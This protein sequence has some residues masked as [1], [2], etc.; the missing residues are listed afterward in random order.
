MASEENQL[1]FVERSESFL[2]T[3]L[4]PRVT[5]VSKTSSQTNFS[6]ALTVVDTD[7]VSTAFS[8]EMINTDSSKELANCDS[9]QELADASSQEPT[10]PASSLE[11]NRS[12]SIDSQRSEVN[13]EIDGIRETC[14]SPTQKVMSTRVRTVYS[15][16]SSGGNSGMEV[17]QAISAASNPSDSDS[18]FSEQ[19]IEGTFEESGQRERKTSDSYYIKQ[20]YQ[21]SS[22]ESTSLSVTAIKNVTFKSSRDVEI[23][24]SGNESSTRTVEKTGDF[25]AEGAQHLDSPKDKHAHLDWFGSGQEVDQ[26]LN[27]LKTAREDVQQLIQST[28]MVSDIT[29]VIDND[30]M[31][32]DSLKAKAQESM[33]NNLSTYGSSVDTISVNANFNQNSIVHYPDS[34]SLKKDESATENTECPPRLTYSPGIAIRS[35]ALEELVDKKSRTTPERSDTVDLEAAVRSTR[36][37]EESSQVDLDI[38]KSV[39]ELPSGEAIPHLKKVDFSQ[40]RKTK[41]QSAR[42]ITTEEVNM[43]K[44]TKIQ[45]VSLGDEAHTAEIKSP[46]VHENKEEED[47]LLDQLVDLESIQ[48]GYRFHDVGMM[49]GA[50]GICN[51][52]FDDTDDS[53]YVAAQQNPSALTQPSESFDS[54]ETSS[55]QSTESFSLLNQPSGKELPGSTESLTSFLCEESSSLNQNSSVFSST[56]LQDGERFNQLVESRTSTEFISNVSDSHSPSTLELGKVENKIVMENNDSQVVVKESENTYKSEDISNSTVAKTET[57]TAMKTKVESVVTVSKKETGNKKKSKTKKGGNIAA[58]KKETE[59][60]SKTSEVTDATINSPNI[61]PASHSYIE[62]LAQEVSAEVKK[63]VK[64]EAGNKK[65]KGKNRS[66][67]AKKDKAAKNQSNASAED[68]SASL[69][70]PQASVNIPDIKE[71][72]LSKINDGCSINIPSQTERSETEMATTTQSNVSVNQANLSDSV[73]LGSSVKTLSQTERSETEVAPTS[74]SNINVNQAN[75]SDSVSLGSRV[76]TLSQTE[77]SETEVAPTSQSNINVNQANLSDSVLLGSSVKTLSQTERSETEV[78]PTSQSNINVNQANLSDSVSLGSSVKTL[79]QTERSET[80]MESTTQSNMNVNQANLSDSVSLGSSVKTLSQTERSE[81]E[82]ESTTQSNMNVNQAN[83]SDSVSLGS[84]VKT[85]SQTERSE[86]EMESTTQSNMNVN[87]A[88]LSDSVSLGSS[89]KTLSQTERSETEMESTTQSNMNVNQANLSDS[90]SLGSSVKTLSQTERSETEMATTTQSNVSVNQANL[91]DS[92]SLGSSVKTLSQ[93]ELSET[94]VAP[95]SQSSVIVNQAN[96]SDSVLLGSNVKTLSQTERLESEV[97]STTQSNISVN[98]ANLSDSV[99]LGSSVKT[100]SQTERLESEVASTTQ[101]N[102]SVNQANLSDSV[103]LGSSVKTL[104]QTERLESEVASTTQS[105]ISVNQANLSDSVSLGS[106][107]KTLSQTERL[108]S[109]VASTTQSNISVNQANLSDS[110]SLGSS[111]KTLS[112]TE[113]LETEVAPTSQSN[114]SV[115]QANLS[116]SVS[117]GSS[118]KTLSQTERLE[119]EVASTTQSNI[120]VNQANLSDSVSLGSSVKT[121]SQTERSETEVLSTKSI[122]SVNQTNQ[123]S[124]LS[125]GSSVSITKE[126]SLKINTK[127]KGASLLKLTAMSRPRR[128]IPVTRRFNVNQKFESSLKSLGGILKSESVFIDIYFD[129]P[130]FDLT[131]ADCWLRTHNGRWQLHANFCKLLNDETKREYFEIESTNVILETLERILKSKNAKATSDASVAL[132]VVRSGLK[133]FVRYRTTRKTYVL[134]DMTI[135]LELP[136]YGFWVGSVTSTGNGGRRP[137][138]ALNEIY[139]FWKKTGVDAL[140]LLRD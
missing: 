90:V 72:D 105:N 35:Y 88:N 94:E 49:I 26:G 23:G 12:I 119:S 48:V 65:N 21:I 102:I 81:T 63:V 139:A 113:R 131:L 68:A 57:E 6:L 114:I 66:S 126:G 96:L 116:D 36:F 10:N 8:H 136:E 135:D 31:G 128:P 41:E 67:K 137:C 138:D 101:S 52:A 123:S 37:D 112:Q 84:S 58:A 106:S 60:A 109:E 74:Q 4:S 78:A 20:T 82:M 3:P 29:S 115:N 25:V 85:L 99:S 50:G 93:T 107:V 38:G 17:D 24:K 61:S 59:M 51:M 111:V 19:V 32:P 118:V 127:E 47:E 70:Q 18:P 7:L 122:I 133:E 117:L 103:S 92:V 71:T 121:L 100:L 43:F 55:G 22:T 95:T 62:K 79:S 108:E 73:S 110:V 46:T 30:S 91:S 132:F 13:V 11:L 97:A 56:T 2:E 15:R 14:F 125:Q 87:Q 27:R 28:Y 83:L 104:S 53:A 134:Q 124:L 64:Q 69:C 39:D 5:V 42:S 98:Q 75:L 76:K 16:S 129:T 1:Q 89:V 130:D 40:F 44:V 33:T 54:L 140:N 9:S 34:L 45:K 80:E 86:T 120:S 77:R